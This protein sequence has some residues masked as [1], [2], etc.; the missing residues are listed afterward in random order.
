MLSPMKKLLAIIVLGLFLTGCVAIGNQNLE[1]ENKINEPKVIAVNVNSGGPWMRTIERGLK[2]AG[3]KV[4]RS[5]SVNEA[6]EVSGAANYMF[7]TNYRCEK[8]SNKF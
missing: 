8:V 4:L 1:I 6:I 2:K 7:Y 3:F 5:S